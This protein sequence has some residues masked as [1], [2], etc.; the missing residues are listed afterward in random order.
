M[1]SRVSNLSNLAK[2]KI[3]S[4]IANLENWSEI[5]SLLGSENP[6]NPEIL[7][8][9]N[10]RFNNKYDKRQDIIDKLLKYDNIPFKFCQ[11]SS[12]VDIINKCSLN[13]LD[14]ICFSPE[15]PNVKLGNF[16]KSHLVR[17]PMLEIINGIKKNPDYKS[18]FIRGFIVKSRH[19][20]KIIDDWCETGMTTNLIDAVVNIPNL[21]LKYSI[22]DDSLYRRGLLNVIDNL[23]ISLNYEIDVL[24]ENEKQ[25]AH[26]RDL[27]EKISKCD[28]NIEE[29]SKLYS[30]DQIIFDE[31]TSRSLT[32]FIEII[33][34]LEKNA[35]TKN[36]RNWLTTEFSGVY[37]DVYTKCSN[38]V[39]AGLY[40]IGK[41][42]SHP[43]FDD[44][45]HSGNT[46]SWTFSHG[47]I[48]FK[49]GK[50]EYVRRILTEYVYS[51][52]NL[53]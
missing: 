39:D 1:T 14:K 15:N 2:F 46:C 37:G 32:N 43:S 47:R 40:Y 53:I 11:T 29:F 30:I 5:T 6:I 16:I 51:T 27:A 28:N 20:Q 33:E 4:N 21:L 34:S 48:Y 38:N 13:D 35:D 26:T 7:K 49:F 52:K 3:Y 50:T 25:M 23:S 41:I 31:Q 12:I 10:I 9:N 19:E 18:D 8:K 22:E 24:I 17:N 45:G 44:L 42:T 36:I